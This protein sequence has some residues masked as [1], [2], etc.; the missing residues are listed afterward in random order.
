MCITDIYIYTS[1]FSKSKITFQISTTLFFLSTI[2]IL[3]INEDDL[4]RDKWRRIPSLSV[5]DIY[6]QAFFV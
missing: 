5:T 4:P 3:D 6:K 2:V 1:N